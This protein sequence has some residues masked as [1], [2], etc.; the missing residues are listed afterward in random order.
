MQSALSKPSFALDVDQSVPANV[1][2]P[3]EAPVEPDSSD[4][5]A[6]RAAAGAE[7]AGI[8]A[9]KAKIK[10]LESVYCCLTLLK[11]RARAIKYKTA[12]KEL[13]KKH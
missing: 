3:H 2:R 13:R 10:E 11:T 1:P 7:S 5:D 4:S 6:E 8:V 12:N 9:L